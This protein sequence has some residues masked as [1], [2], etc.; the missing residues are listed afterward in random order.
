MNIA[1]PEG[2]LTPARRPQVDI[3][4]FNGNAESII[5]KQIEEH[6]NYA[7]R[8]M[9]EAGCDELR[10][11][12]LLYGATEGYKSIYIEEL[13]FDLPAGV[14]FETTLNKKKIPSE[15]RAYD[16]EGNISYKISSYS[17]GS[18]N[19]N[20]RFNTNNGF[21]FVW[22]DIP[23]DTSKITSVEEWKSKGNH[24]AEVN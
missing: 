11:I 2:V 9:Q 8:T 14:K 19:F 16:N 23:I 12:I 13:P 18:D 22:P 7:Y 6:R 1:I 3:E 15:Y 5:T 17:K 4:Q 21:L 24:V 10:S 20:K